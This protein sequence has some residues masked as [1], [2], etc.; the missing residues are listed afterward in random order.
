MT[1]VRLL[2]SVALSLPLALGCS[3]A[4]ATSLT[5]SSSPLASASA[6]PPAVSAAA[7]SS[8]SAKARALANA[9]PPDPSVVERLKSDVRDVSIEREPGTP[10]WK[11]VQDLIGGRLK[12]HGFEVE[13]HSW[14]PISK[15]VIGK[16]KGTKK[17]DEI[18]ILSAHYDHVWGC[19]GADDNGSGVAVVLEAARV[20]GE[21][22]PERT[23]VLAFWDHEESG[24]YGSSA[25][26]T[27]ARQ[28]K[29]DIRVMISLDGVGF[30]DSRP[31]AQQ[32][33]DGIGL[34]VPDLVQ[35]LEE[36]EHRGDFIAVIGDDESD[37]A[38]R[39][40]DDHGVNRGLPVLGA[41][42]SAI[43]RLALID[44]ARSDHASFW[45]G[46]FPGILV[47]DTANFRN[48]RYHCGAGPDTPESLDYV[49]LAKV[50]LTT[51]DVVKSSLH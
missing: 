7:A 39:A 48:P 31:G 21:I 37:H 43:G 8:P 5:A 33:P 1:K 18:V 27:R 45:L 46:G 14:Q 35:E 4:P 13:N 11:K 32:M 12:K 47:T 36:R 20:L 2:A 3:P 26:V 22:E 51:I 6:V 34:V 44:A 29:E 30:V 50:A 15:N 28:R 25:Y 17:P 16:K 41:A 49:F 42:L 24:L 10:G 19:Q 40:F 23:L 9:A 38:V